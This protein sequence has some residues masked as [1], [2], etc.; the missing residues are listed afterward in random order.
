[1]G[2]A[3]SDHMKKHTSKCSLVDSKLPPKT[4]SKLTRCDGC[5]S[6]VLSCVY[7]AHIATCPQM[8]A[9]MA[10]F[11]QSSAADSGTQ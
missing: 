9:L 7:E 3:R 8:A 2:F 4:D 11:D 10:Q 6:T 1:M 5:G